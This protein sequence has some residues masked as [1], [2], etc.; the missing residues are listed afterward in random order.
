[1]TVFTVYTDGA[2][3]PTNPGPSGYG[4]VLYDDG[5]LITKEGGY[6][7][8][9]YSNNQAEY[10]G[11]LAGLR[12]ATM[13]L[14]ANVKEVIIRADSLLVINQIMGVWAL[15]VAKL[16]PLHAAAVKALSDLQ[17]LT[18]VRLEHVRGHKGEEGNEA[19]DALAGFAVEQHLPASPMVMKFVE[20]SRDKI[21]IVKKGH[22]KLEDLVRSTFGVQSFKP[23]LTTDQ[24]AV[25][26]QQKD[27]TSELVLQFP[28]LIIAKDG[29]THLL[30]LATGFKMLAHPTDP[31]RAVRTMDLSAFNTAKR[32]A[33]A[34]Y[35]ILVAHRPHSKDRWMTDVDL[36]WGVTGAPV[37]LK[38]ASIDTL[39]NGKIFDKDGWPP[40]VQ[41]NGF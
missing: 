31:P 12:L 17:K 5:K 13:F 7:G 3:R 8:E 32:L 36:G 41:V 25:L 40:F 24:R 23:L 34:G 26:N 2:T 33:S 4:A 37:P 18:P 35:Q 19:A 6:L 38:I 21:T 39:S 1:M 11:M 27:A 16:G 30:L 29:T 14:H 9:L 10:A 28:Q 15:R 22:E 20:Q